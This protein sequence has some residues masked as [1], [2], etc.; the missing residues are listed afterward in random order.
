MNPKTGPE[1]VLVTGGG[2]FLGSA[3][4][5]Q[6]KDR[7]DRVTGFSRRYYP[8]L[9][10]WGVPQIQGDLTDARAVKDA[11]QGMDLVIHTAAKAGVWGS[12]RAYYEANVLGTEHVIQGC[13]SAGVRRLVYT[14]SPSVVFDGRDMEGVDESVPYPDVFEAPYPET[15]AAAEQRVR[16]AARQELPAVILRPHLIWGP[17][18]PHIL[19]GIVSRASRLRR[20]GNGLNRVDTIYVD[21]AAHAHLLAADQLKTHPELSGRI[22]FISQDEPVPLW[23]MVDR[24]LDAAGLPPVEKTISAQ[25]AWMAGKVFETLYRIFPLKGEPPMTAFAAR[26]M[27]TAHWFDISRARRD[28]GYHP[29]ISITQGMER[30][31]QWIHQV[32]RDS[33]IP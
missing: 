28:L 16:Q 20:I 24:F 2:G 9:A 26:E 33:L 12:H 15:K 4:V 30:L 27:A 31:K 29:R 32:G 14:S 11:C 22:Y 21:N 25:G 23:E 7:G 8:R 18:D 6:F 1:N 13:I 10:E 17:E 5:R 3:V 19:P